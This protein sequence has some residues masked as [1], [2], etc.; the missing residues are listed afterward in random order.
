MG[1]TFLNMTIVM[2]FRPCL[3]LAMIDRG[4]RY[5]VERFREH[6]IFPS[7]SAIDGMYNFQLRSGVSL[8]ISRS[9]HG[10]SSSGHLFKNIELDLMRDQLQI[11]HHHE[12]L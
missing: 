7:P 12:T 1:N 2:H 9:S 6:T 3:V 5:L 10:L 8:H 11:S 4:I